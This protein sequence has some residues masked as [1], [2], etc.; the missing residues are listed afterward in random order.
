[1]IQLHYFHVVLTRVFVYRTFC[2]ILNR[3]DLCYT[4]LAPS[5]KLQFKDKQI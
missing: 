3:F 1:M 2:N 4:K 5:D